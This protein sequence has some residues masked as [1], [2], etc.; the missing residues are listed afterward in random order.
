MPVGA[1]N[2]YKFLS[3]TVE[4]GA[5][6]H[7]CGGSGRRWSYVLLP[8]HCLFIVSLVCPIGLVPGGNTDPEN[9]GGK[10]NAKK[11]VR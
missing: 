7:S 11:Q 8:W 5:G 4:E 10:K 1:A 6:H 2:Y 3:G 9:A